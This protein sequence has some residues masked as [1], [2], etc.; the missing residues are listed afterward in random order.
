[1]NREEAQDLF[2]D[3]IPDNPFNSYNPCPC[4][5]GK[6]LRFLLKEDGK[7]VEKHFEKFVKD[8]MTPTEPIAKYVEHYH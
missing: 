8:H 6:K 5:C 4:G 1:M 7:E 3:Q 2:L